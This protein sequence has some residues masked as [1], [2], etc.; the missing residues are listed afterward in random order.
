MKPIYSCIEHE[1]LIE[2]YMKSVLDGIIP[3]VNNQ[4][5]EIEYIEILNAIIDYHNEYGEQYNSG[6]YYDFL[7]IIPLQLSIMSSGFL[8]GISNKDN[9]LQ[10]QIQKQLLYN[11]TVKV[12]ENLH[13]IKLKHE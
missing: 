1:V 3:L 6:N 11:R 12:V 8:C 7:T 4:D 2:D 10:I 9:T 13:K 5:K